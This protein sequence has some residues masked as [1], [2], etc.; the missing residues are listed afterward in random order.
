MI[1]K[2]KIISFSG[3]WGSGLATLTIQNE[4]GTV[5]HVPCDNGPTVRALHAAFG[6]VISKNHTMNNKAIQGKEIYYTLD[7]MGLVLGGFVPLEMASKEL[8]QTYENQKEA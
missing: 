6:N 4:D 1:Q 7:D 5:K 3:S 2:G 8:I